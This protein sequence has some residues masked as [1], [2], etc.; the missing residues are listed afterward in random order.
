MQILTQ[1]NPLSHSNSIKKRSE[2]SSVTCI[3]LSLWTHIHFPS[4]F[5]FMIMI[6]PLVWFN[7]TFYQQLAISCYNQTKSKEKKT[8]K[9]NIFSN[10]I[11]IFS[12]RLHLF[13]HIITVKISC[14][15]PV[16][17]GRNDTSCHEMWYTNGTVWI[18]KMGF[19]KCYV[20]VRVKVIAWTSD[21]NS[22]TCI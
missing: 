1:S 14:F 18:F 2:S 7:D 17:P 15:Y 22:F 20:R 12:V 5:Y 11:W 6:W 9:F 21:I 16:T 3:W 10:T 19:A 8:Q 13:S 4:T